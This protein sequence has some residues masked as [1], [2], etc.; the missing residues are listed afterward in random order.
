MDYSKLIADRYSVRKFEN[1]HLTDLQIN[2][3]LAAGHT[4]PTGCNIQPQRILVINTD[5]ST[6]KL[7]PC[8]KCHFDAPCAFL[9]CFDK[10]ECW[11]RKYD[12]ALSGAIDASIVTTH[13]M[14]KIHD[15][16]LGSTWVMHF[17]PVKMRETFNIPDS[18]EPVA[19]LVAGHPAKDAAPIQMHFEQ[20]P[21]D[22][23]VTYDSF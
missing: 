13:M 4:A 8:T 19:L 14:L 18:I 12:G 23:T 1:K 22:E 5:E 10:T 15:M 2:E 3:I 11:K 6:E 7:K 21:L 20:R 17:D 16:G 9:V